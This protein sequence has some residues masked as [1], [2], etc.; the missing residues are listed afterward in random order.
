M[1]TGII[2]EIGVVKALERG[3]GTATTSGVALSSRRTHGG[4]T[5]SPSVACA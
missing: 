2:E 5:R 3:G 1:F 4:A